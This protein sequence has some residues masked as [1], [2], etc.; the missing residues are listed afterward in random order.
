MSLFHSAVTSSRSLVESEEIIASPMIRPPP[1]QLPLPRTNRYAV[2]LIV[3]MSYS[4]SFHCFELIYV[5][6]AS[7]EN[8]MFCV[9]NGRMLSFIGIYVSH[10]SYGWIDYGYLMP[11]FPD[12]KSQIL[13]HSI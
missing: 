2:F 1:P 8:V 3:T 4:E 11:V 10:P 7:N 6:V 13:F 5:Y 9:S 12:I